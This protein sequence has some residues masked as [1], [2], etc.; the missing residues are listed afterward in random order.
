MSLLTAFFNLIKP[1]KTDGVKVSDFNSNMDIIDTEMHR[2]PLSVNG[3]FPDSTTRDFELEEVPL[4]GNLSSEEI[5]KEA[6]SSFG[7]F[8]E[9]S[10]GGAASI[11][12]GSAWLVSMKGN[13]VKTGYIAESLTMTVTPAEREEGVDPITATIDRD[14]FVAYVSTSGTTTLTYTTAW[15]ADPTDYGITVTGT[16]IS[17][18]EITVVYVKENRGTI[19]SATP[20]AFNSTGWNLYNNTTGYAKVVKYSDSYGFVIGGTYS[21]LEFA[22]TV[23]GTRSAIVPVDGYFSVPSD[24]YVFVTGGNATDTEIYMT[25]SDWIDTADHPSFEAYTVDEIDISEAMVTFPYGL[26]SVGVVRDEIN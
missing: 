19:T 26:M 14:T 25:W 21:L 15:S 12:D 4:A 24:G 10:S 6:Q 3:V 5:K 13:S 23:T 17:G 2:P 16:P 9:R 18:D 8:I 11:A 7:T 1:A 20:T 22:T